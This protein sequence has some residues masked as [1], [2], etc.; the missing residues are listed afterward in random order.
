MKEVKTLGSFPKEQHFAALEFIEQSIYHEGD[1]RSRTYPGHGYPAYTETR[2]YVIYR[3]FD[4][5][6]ELKEWIIKANQD[7]AR[8]QVIEVRPVN[9]KVATTV[10]L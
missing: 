9:F 6:E 5:A 10:L 3:I 1:E 4:S 2:E 8:F 7:K